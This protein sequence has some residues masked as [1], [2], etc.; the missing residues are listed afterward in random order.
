MGHAAG[1]QYHPTPATCAEP[2]TPHGHE[3]SRAKQV[4]AIVPPLPIVE[5]RRAA[6]IS[7]EHAR[8]ALHSCYG[9][10]L[11][12]ARRAQ[13]AQEGEGGTA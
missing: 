4:R 3:G 9:I 8:A 6:G 2:T 7:D 10:I 5:L 1:S 12:A 13:A 11:N